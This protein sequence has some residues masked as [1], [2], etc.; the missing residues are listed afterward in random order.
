M[1]CGSSSQDEV[2]CETQE[3]GDNNK[4]QRKQQVFNIIIIYIFINSKW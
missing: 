3:P 1:G 4:K 2:N